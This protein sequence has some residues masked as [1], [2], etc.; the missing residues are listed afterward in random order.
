MISARTEDNGVRV[1]M[2]G[3]VDAIMDEIA[4]TT[5]SLLRD[6]LN[7]TNEECAKAV[8]ADICIRVRQVFLNK[9]NVDLF[10]FNV[11]DDVIHFE[12]KE[13]KSLDG[14]ARMVLD[15]MSSAVADDGMEDDLPNFFGQR[16]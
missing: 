1:K 3:E 13:Q 10:D 2:G 6:C 8:F 11:I 16:G 14:L 7:D 9:N 15:G 5:Y 12:S 4:Y